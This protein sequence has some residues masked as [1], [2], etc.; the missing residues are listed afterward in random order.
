MPIITQ[1]KKAKKKYPNSISRGDIVEIIEGKGFYGETLKGKKAEIINPHI[2]GG[3]IVIRILEEENSPD[4]FFE[5][6]KVKK[7]E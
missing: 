1:T 4:I 7:I 2:P 3:M 6:K 5:R